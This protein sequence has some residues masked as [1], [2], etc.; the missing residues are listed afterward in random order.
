MQITGRTGVVG[1]VDGTHIKI[2]K[3]S[4]ITLFLM[5]LTN[6]TDVAVWCF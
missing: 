5:Q 6:L 4:G 1:V 2:I 3:N